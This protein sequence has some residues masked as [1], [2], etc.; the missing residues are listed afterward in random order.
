VLPPPKNPENIPPRAGSGIER[1][2]DGTP[3]YVNLDK[4]KP[5]ETEYTKL[6]ILTSLFRIGLGY[7]CEDDDS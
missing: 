1:S 7:E 4:S 5:N 2:Y 3:Q 6:Q